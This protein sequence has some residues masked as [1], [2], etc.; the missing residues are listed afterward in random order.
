MVKKRNTGRGT[1]S[2]GAF[3]TKVALLQTE[4]TGGRPIFL[5]YKVRRA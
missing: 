4:W 2:G 3:E 5:G 1:R